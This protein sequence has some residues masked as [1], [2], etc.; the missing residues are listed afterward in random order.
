MYKL[1]TNF[2]NLAKFQKNNTVWHQKTSEC[3]FHLWYLPVSTSVFG[4]VCVCTLC[5]LSCDVWGFL[6]SIFHGQGLPKNSNALGRPGSLFSQWEP[7]TDYCKL[8]FTSPHSQEHHTEDAC[9]TSP[10][11]PFSIPLIRAYRVHI[12]MIC[13]IFGI[14]PF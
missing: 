1:K 7:H 14:L 6:F 5:E 12:Q 4:C 9:S 2:V 11:S 13:V 8:H 3:T 10:Y